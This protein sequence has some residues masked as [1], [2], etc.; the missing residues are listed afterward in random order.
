MARTVARGSRSNFRSRSNSAHSRGLRTPVCPAILAAYRA[1]K[2][3]KRRAGILTVR[4]A[5][6]EAMEVCS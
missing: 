5:N 3:V 6:S 4:V 1:L 2:G